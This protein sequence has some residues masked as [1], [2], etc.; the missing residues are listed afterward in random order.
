MELWIIQQFNWIH[1]RNL[2]FVY[3]VSSHLRTRQSV[4]NVFELITRG[5]QI[6]PPLVY[7]IIYYLMYII[8]DN[9]Y[10]S[11]YSFTL[12]DYTIS[13]SLCFMILFAGGLAEASIC[14]FKKRN[15]TNGKIWLTPNRYIGRR[16][17]MSR[18]TLLIAIDI[19]I[20]IIYS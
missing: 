16:R 5:R 9:I 10:S 8:F 12:Y 13:N 4:P 6:A 15:K 7:N 11:L 17:Y 1:L 3:C 19:I 2:G 20:C 14:W 18:Y